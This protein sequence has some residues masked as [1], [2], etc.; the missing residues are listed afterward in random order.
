ME[1]IL[2]YELLG[3]I[4]NFELSFPDI[5]V[6]DDISIDDGEYYSEKE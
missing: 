1:Y 3:W 6:F 2:S 4:N 5:E